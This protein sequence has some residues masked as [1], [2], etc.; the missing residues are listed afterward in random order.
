MDSDRGEKPSL[1]ANKILMQKYRRFLRLNIVAN[2][3]DVYY[4][5]VV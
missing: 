1:I 3:C 2:S 5:T 4:F